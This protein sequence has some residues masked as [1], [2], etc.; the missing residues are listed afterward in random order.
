[1]LGRSQ[2]VEDDIQM[3]ADALYQRMLKHEEAVEQA[4]KDGTPIPVFESVVPRLGPNTVQPTDEVQKSWKDK[5]DKLPEDER[6]AEEAAL[7]ADLQ[8]K[9]DVA[10]GIKGIYQ[11]KEDERHARQA[12]GQATFSDTISALLGGKGRG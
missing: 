2:T 3:H 5:L 1:M 12:A 10:K 4:K 9:A 8:V 11:S 7:R 6:E